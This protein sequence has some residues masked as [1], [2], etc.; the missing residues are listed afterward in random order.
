MIVLF[1]SSLISPLITGTNEFLPL[2][3]G[4]TSN[5]KSVNVPKYGLLIGPTFEDNFFL[6]SVHIRLFN[7]SNT[8][9]LYKLAIKLPF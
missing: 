9:K 4:K 7:I 3:N 1:I 2:T 8:A 6:L 5:V